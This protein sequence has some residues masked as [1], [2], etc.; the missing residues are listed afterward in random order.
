MA[1]L[2]K[3]PLHKVEITDLGGGINEA[4][5]VTKL[6]IRECIKCTNFRVSEDGLTKE[7]RQ[8]TTKL[9]SVY[10]FGSKKVYGVYGIEEEDEV[11]ILACLEDSIQLKSEGDWTEIFA[12]TTPPDKPV[13]IVQ[14]KG[15]VLIAGYEKLI[16]VKDG[17][18]FYSGVEA[19]QSAP[20]V[21]TQAAET[22]MKE[23]EYPAS[24]QD[25]CGELGAS[26]AQTL[27][28]QSFRVSQNC[29]L[30]KV[31]IKLKKIGSPTGNLWVEIHSSKS[32]TSTT[33]EASTN[34]V[35]QATDNLDVSTLTGSFT[36]KELSFSGTKPSLSV[37]TTYYLVV[38]RSFAV[39]ST[40][41]VVVGFDN[42]DP[43]YSD[44]KYWEIDGSLDWSNYSAIDVVFE[45]YG[46]RTDEE[47]VLSFGVKESGYSYIF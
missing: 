28:S 26:A 21:D 12:P 15:L 32:G 40:N 30:T 8:G 5:V 18:A 35:G 7:K 19:P 3:T 10:S 43:S 47:E 41:F 14:D 37:D 9:D 22:D 45:I 20:T 29:D 23:V 16:T 2:K 4:A 36:D 11:K 25:N 1:S 13:S 38:Y 24:N 6:P 31:K 34:I 27:L 33:K 39:S 17:S 46:L 42:S 44:G